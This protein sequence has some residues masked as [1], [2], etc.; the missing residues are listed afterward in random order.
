[1]DSL[2]VMSLYSHWHYGIPYGAMIDE[3]G[4][5]DIIKLIQLINILTTWV[6][7]PEG[8]SEVKEKMLM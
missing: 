3:P 8:Q 7:W 4:S 2:C 5:G 1:M 6:L